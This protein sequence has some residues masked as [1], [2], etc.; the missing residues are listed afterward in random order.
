MHQ[1]AKTTINLK[2]LC[3]APLIVFKYLLDTNHVVSVLVNAS[4]RTIKAI[5]VVPDCQVSKATRAI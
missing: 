3:A 2:Q 5:L 4:Y 1:P